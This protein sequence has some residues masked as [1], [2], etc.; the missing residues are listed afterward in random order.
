MR[1]RYHTEDCVNHTRFQIST[2]NDLF[3]KWRRP[4][5]LVIRHFKYSQILF[6]SIRFKVWP[7]SNTSQIS[8]TGKRIS[9]CFITV[10]YMI[11][12]WRHI[13]EAELSRTML[14]EVQVFLWDLG[15]LHKLLWFS[16]KRLFRFW[17]RFAIKIVKKYP[18]EKTIWNDQ[19]P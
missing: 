13:K 17:A 6:H 10:V 8:L 2:E 4:K 5:M 11:S 19:R 12:T 14:A 3:V 7:L 18:L 15:T 1:S 9:R 16:S